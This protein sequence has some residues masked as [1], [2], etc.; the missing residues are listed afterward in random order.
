M[1]DVNELIAGT[2]SMDEFLEANMNL[3]YHFTNKYRFLPNFEDIQQEAMIGIYEAA[4]RF[5]PSFGTTFSTYAQYFVH[6]RAVRNVFQKESVIKIPRPVLECSTKLKRFYPEIT[7]LGT[8]AELTGFTE[9][10]IIR[11][12]EY[13]NSQ[14]TSLDKPADVVVGEG[15]TLG[16]LLGKEDLDVCGDL[17]IEQF[18]ATLTERECIVLTMRLEG[19]TQPEISKVVG[20]TQVQVSR[21]LKK[22]QPKLL[23]FLNGGLD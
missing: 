12:L 5:D 18:M 23:E 9:K 2:M 11:A 3:V 22:M 17:L 20:V 19:C 7:E 13:I 10:E 4:V 15:S 1:S 21:I 8:L 16:E 6:K 14:V